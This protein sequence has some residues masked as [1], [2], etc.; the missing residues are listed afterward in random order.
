MELAMDMNTVIEI[1]LEHAMILNKVN[2]SYEINEVT[3]PTRVTRVT[4]PTRVTRVTRK[5]FRSVLTYLL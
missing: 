4:S 2:E 1:D 5:L 3:S